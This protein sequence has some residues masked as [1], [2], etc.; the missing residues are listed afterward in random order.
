MILSRVHLCGMGR[1]T[2]HSHCLRECQNQDLLPRVVLGKLEH[3]KELTLTLFFNPVKRFY[4]RMAIFA[5]MGE[6]HKRQALVI[7]S[8][9]VWAVQMTDAADFVNC[10][11]MLF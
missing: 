3:S 10:C 6:S 4:Y 8:A 7:G 5:Y 9:A 1:V 2:D 11:A